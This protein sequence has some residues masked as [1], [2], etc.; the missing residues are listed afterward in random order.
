MGTNSFPGFDSI[1]VK[2]KFTEIV[3]VLL[4]LWRIIFCFIPGSSRKPAEEFASAVGVGEKERFTGFCGQQLGGLHASAVGVLSD[5]D[6]QESTVTVQCA[7][8]HQVLLAI[9]TDHLI[10]EDGG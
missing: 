5:T 10:F 9:R 3:L 6:G 1:G 4:W 8:L 2:V 7:V